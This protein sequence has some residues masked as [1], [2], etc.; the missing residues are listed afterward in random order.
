MARSRTSRDRVSRHESKGLLTGDVTQHV[1]PQ[2]MFRISASAQR[3]GKA[4]FEDMKEAHTLCCEMK[5]AAREGKAKIVYRPLGSQ[6]LLFTYFNAALGRKNDG[7]AQAGKFHLP[8]D[9]SALNTEQ[10]SNLLEYHSSKISRVVRS[11]MAAES[12]ALSKG[13]DYQLYNRL[14]YDAL[15]FGRVEIQEDWRSQLRVEGLMVTDAKAVFDHC[16][17]T[18]HLAQE[19]QTAID[20]PMTRRLIEERRLSVRWVPTFK[21]PADSLTKSMKDL[22]LTTWKR[23]GLICLTST[24]E[25]QQEECH[26]SQI[27]RATRTASSTGEAVW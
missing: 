21:Q 8:T 27:R 24:A 5:T 26:R 3:V 7:S 15:C 16:R 9:K 25:D 20:L 19:R 10:P 18:G 1:F 11:S 12:C 14:L 23:D 6:T 22:L 2:R 13:A 17:T 4:V